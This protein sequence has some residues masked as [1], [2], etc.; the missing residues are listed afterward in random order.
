MI[1][2]CVYPKQVL[3][4]VDFSC[5]I[6]ALASHLLGFVR[7]C[8]IWCSQGEANS[9]VWHESYQFMLES[10]WT[11]SQTAEPKLHE[12]DNEEQLMEGEVGRVHLRLCC[13]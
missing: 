3:A 7:L 2:I 12:E 5:S 8:L 6:C 1:P 11:I 13:L 10:F 4:R 9:I